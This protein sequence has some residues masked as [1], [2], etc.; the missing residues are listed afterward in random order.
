MEPTIT[1]TAV[2]KTRAAFESAKRG[3]D[4]IN[5]SSL[6]LNQTLG[7]L[8]PT[9]GT[10]SLLAFAKSAIDAQDELSKLSQKTGIGVESLAGL[11]HAADLSGIEV[12][13]LAKGVRTFSVLVDQ[14]ANG[15][16]SYQDKLVSL[17]LNYKQLKDLSPEKQFYALADAVSKLGKEDRATAV[18]GALGDRLSVLVPLLSGGSDEMRKLVEEGQRLN[19][20]TQESARRAEE[21]N[22]NL[23]RLQ[24][25]AGLAGIELATHLLPSLADTAQAMVDLSREGHGV[26]AMWRGFAGLGKIPWDLLIGDIEPARTAQERIKELR[27]ELGTLQRQA[28]RGDGKLMQMIF[29]TPK[30]IEQQMTV[31]KN[32]IAALEKFG[33]KIYTPKAPKVPSNSDDTASRLACLA[34]GGTWDGSKCRPK[35]TGGIDKAS[36]QADDIANAW[37]QATDELNQYHETERIVAEFDLQRDNQIN[38]IAQAWKD[39]GEALTRDMLTPTEQFQQRLEYIDELFRRGVISQDTLDRATADAFDKPGAKIKETTDLAKEL[40]L[41]FNSAFEDAAV[42]GKK[43]GDVLKGLAQDLARL[44]L[45]KAVT[46]PLANSVG[47]WAASLFPS[48]NG[49]AFANAPA[50]SAYSGTVQTSPFVFPFANGGVPNFGV[51][52]EAGPEGI[53]PLKR[54]PDGKLGI[55]AQGAGGYVDNRV[56]NIDARGSDAG[57]EERIRRAISE[58]EDRAVNRSVAQVQNLNRRGALRLS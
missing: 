20:I 28:D 16:K 42:S 57:V 33:E 23:S 41:T 11:Q 12:D 47:N 8:L 1:L 34:N 38:D 25:E 36:M 32:Q 24:K 27:I 6:V 55:S 52:A 51:G 50:L 26:L 29:G 30:E 31:I 17:G 58:S 15:Q 44:V 37:Q 35:Q 56:Y 54:G 18:A 22:D 4:G 2:D 43:F 53:F 10:V 21:F 39:A 45:R 3:L 9:L 13:Q 19:P 40:G 48:A 49:N 5:K 14:A 46:E 7:L